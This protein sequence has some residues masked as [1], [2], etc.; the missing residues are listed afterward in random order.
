MSCVLTIM[1]CY[2]TSLRIFKCLSLPGEDM[3]LLLNSLLFCWLPDVDQLPLWNADNCLIYLLPSLPILASRRVWLH[4]PVSVV[5]HVYYFFRMSWCCA[6]SSTV[7]L[8]KTFHLI[9]IHR[10]LVCNPI[11]SSIGLLCIVTAT[12]MAA[13]W[14][15]TILVSASA[16]I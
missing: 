15:Y 14:S 2:T 13:R 12:C 4:T 16:I 6:L 3:A 5:R 11:S 8:P 9:L 10:T 7:S 1:A